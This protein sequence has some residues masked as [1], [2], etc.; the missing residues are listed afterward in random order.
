MQYAIFLWVKG[1]Y[2]VFSFKYILTYFF[3]S[4]QKIFF[5]HHLG[6]GDAIVHNGMV[7]KYL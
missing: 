3:M 2:I 4:N 5:K 1:I 7:R 6:M